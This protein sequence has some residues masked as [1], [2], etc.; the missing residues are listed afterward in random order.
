[1][2]IT[3]VLRPTGV[4]DL[5]LLR[6]RLSLLPLRDKLLLLLLLGE[7]RR[8]LRLGVRLG[9]RDRGDMLRRGVRDLERS[10]GVRDR[11]LLRS[12][13]GEGDAMVFGIIGC[14]K[15]VV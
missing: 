6:L 13:M 4:G 12:L 2:N 5:P 3:F 9:E 7:S 14:C 11:D 8:P 10:N 15:R 1:M